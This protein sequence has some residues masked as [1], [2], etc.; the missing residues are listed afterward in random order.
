MA[1]ATRTKVSDGR[2]SFVTV[3]GLNVICLFR[4]APQSVSVAEGIP[5]VVVIQ[6]DLLDALSIRLTIPLA[7]IDFEGKVPTKLCPIITV[8]AQRLR[9][10][11]HYA[12]PLPTKLLQRPVDNVVTQCSALVVALG[13]LLT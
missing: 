2:R 5:Y 4:L 7:D 6:S 8:K 9:A 12:A 10:L 11:A 13:A 1:G 3:G